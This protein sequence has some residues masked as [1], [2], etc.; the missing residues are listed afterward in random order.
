VLAAYALNRHFCVLLDARRPD[1][2]EQWYRVMQCIRSTTLRNP[3]QGTHVAG[4][5]ALPAIGT[6]QVPTRKIWV[7]K[8]QLTLD[9]QISMFTD[10]PPRKEKLALFNQ[11]DSRLE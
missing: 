11:S 8:T 6:R 3:M 7:M 1:L 5:G 4:T 10:S 9:N 2:L